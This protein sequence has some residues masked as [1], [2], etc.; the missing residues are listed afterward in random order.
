M[1][2]LLIL[3]SP[4]WLFLLMWGSAWAFIYLVGG[5]EFIRKRLPW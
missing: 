5:M 4:L 1:L 2:I 3:T